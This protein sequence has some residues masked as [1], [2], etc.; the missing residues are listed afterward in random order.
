CL[1]S[2]IERYKCFDAK[3]DS[4]MKDRESVLVIGTE[5]SLNTE[6]CIVMDRK[7]DDEVHLQDLSSLREEL[8]VL[9]QFRRNLLGEDL[10]LLSQHKLDVCEDIIVS[11][12]TTLKYKKENLCIEKMKLLKDEYYKLQ[13]M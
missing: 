4:S 2:T 9:E 10:D 5:K 8:R 11:T 7:R 13:N 1:E 6:K 3:L 12:L